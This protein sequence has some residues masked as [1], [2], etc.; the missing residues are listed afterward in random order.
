MIGPR[1]GPRIGLRIGPRVGMLGDS[2]GIPGVTR[3]ASNLNYY[4]ASASEWTS[5]LSFAS[6]STGNPT[7]AWTMQEASGNLLDS[8]STVH[9]TPQVVGHLYQQAV[10]GAT[11]KCVKG[12]AGTVNQRWDNTTNAPNA[13]LT[14]V[15]ILLFCD[16]P[17]TPPPDISGVVRIVMVDADGTVRWNTVGQ[18]R[19]LSG[20]TAGTLVNSV[21]GR[22]TWIYF[23]H[24]RT[25][26]T[27]K[28]FTD[29]EKFGGTYSLPA[30]GINL[31]I[32]GSGGAAGPISGIG[33][34]Y[35]A[36]FTG[37]AAELSDAQVKTLLQTLGATIPWT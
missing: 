22:Q 14:S 21:A 7:S 17:A 26:G 15:S 29:Q 8:V 36:Q 18:L 28:V 24:D 11:R 33:Y 25:A 10:T 6:L 30:S 13:N 12:L 23:Q 37:T 32:G 27:V 9:L 31:C 20:G 35:G 4:P 19:L 3:D 34:A 16:I 2:T 5:L 1:I